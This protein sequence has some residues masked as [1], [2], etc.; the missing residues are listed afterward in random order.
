MKIGTGIHDYVNYY[1]G[2][3]VKS[4]YESGALNSLINDFLR[5]YPK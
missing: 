1:D 3:S 4:Y 2:G 5:K